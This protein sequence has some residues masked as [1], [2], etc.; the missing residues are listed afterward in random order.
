MAVERNPLLKTIEGGAGITGAK[1][2]GPAMSQTA[3]SG[4]LPADGYIK[5]AANARARKLAIAN[6]AMQNAPAG[7]MGPSP[8]PGR[9]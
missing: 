6:R 1:M 3:T 2:Y 4:P 9:I 7:I 8:A 5:R